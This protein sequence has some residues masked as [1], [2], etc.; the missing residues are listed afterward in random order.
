MWL[1]EAP[2]LGEAGARHAV[3]RRHAIPSYVELPSERVYCS[4]NHRCSQLRRLGSAIARSFSSRHADRTDVRPIPRPETLF[5]ND[6]RLERVLRAI[7]RNLGPV[8][9]LKS[10]AMSLCVLSQGVRFRHLPRLPL[11]LCHLVGD[12]RRPPS[13][14]LC[15]RIAIHDRGPHAG[16]DRRAHCHERTSNRCPCLPISQEALPLLAN[17][18]LRRTSP[19]F[20]RRSLLGPGTRRS[21]SIPLSLTL[22]GRGI[23]GGGGFRLCAVS[24]ALLGD[25]IDV[26]RR[27]LRIRFQTQPLAREQPRMRLEVA[28]P[29]TI[30]V[31]TP[32]QATPRSAH[33]PLLPQRSTTTVQQ[34]GSQSASL[35]RRGRGSSA[36]SSG[37][38]RRSGRL[39]ALRRR[40]SAQRRADHNWR[41]M[42]PGHQPQVRNCSRPPSPRPVGMPQSWR[43]SR[44]GLAGARLFAKPNE[45]QRHRLVAIRSKRGCALSS[46]PSSAP[47]TCVGG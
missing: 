43:P 17:S 9:Q 34:H 6:V 44:G 1:Q 15:M 5:R 7:C 45:N 2:L 4:G 41:R 25:S 36:C 42:A 33:R 29:H 30:V 28:W 22:F 12:G 8:L 10:G 21:R 24:I 47:Y 38:E 26:L 11:A 46:T 32:I 13:R 20:A 27:S 19:L 3:G 23:C 37:A 39:A 35:H 31:D 16:I 40:H 14:R 18:S